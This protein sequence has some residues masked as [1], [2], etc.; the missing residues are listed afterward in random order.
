MFHISLS[1]LREK[2]RERNRLVGGERE[3]VFVRSGDKGERVACSNKQL[4]DPR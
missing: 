2:Q 4:V 3:A 1:I